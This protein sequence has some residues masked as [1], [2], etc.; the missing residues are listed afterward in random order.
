M[1]PL[2]IYLLKASAT[3]FILWVFYFLCLRR[4]TFHRLNRYFFITGMILSFVWP[5]LPL[6]EWFFT[7]PQ[8]SQVVVYIPVS[9][10]MLELKPQTP[11][12]EIEDFLK[13]CYVGGV[14]FM[15]IRL[16]IQIFFLRKM[17]HRSEKQ[18]I[19]D[20]PVRVIREQINPFSFFGQI[21]LN[22][23][24]H[25]PSEL[26]AIIQHERVHNHRAHSIDILL[27]ELTKIALWFNPFSWLFCKVVKENIEFEVDRILLHQGIDCKSY[28]Y[29]LLKLS[30][31]KNQ[32]P[33][34]NHFNLSNLK[35]RII[36]MNKK[37]SSRFGLATYALVVPILLFSMIVSVAIAQDKLPK[38]KSEKKTAA[39][40]LKDTLAG[41]KPL[42]LLDGV[43]IDKKKMDDIDP[44]K[45]QTVNVLKDDTGA[46][47]EKGK[48][49]VVII[50]SKKEENVEGHQ[51]TFRQNSTGK[52][53]SDVLFVID[54]VPTENKNGDMPVP[55]QIES[56]SIL[57]DK[58]ATALYGERGKNGV[59]LITT[60]AGNKSKGSSVNFSSPKTISIRSANSSSTPTTVSTGSKLDEVVVVGY[61]SNSVNRQNVIKDT[62]KLK[63]TAKDA[64][65][66]LDGAEI[67]EA[68]MKGLEGSEILKVEVL[69]GESATAI[70]GNKGKNGVI[71]ITSKK[72]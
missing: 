57:K 49:G 63:L 22:P 29:S 42:I 69:K 58:S 45:I 48:D 23:A 56:L 7:T 40:V 12:F 44:E 51:I 10:F 53:P 32:I 6:E 15:L 9:A 52:I 20:V 55:E 35:I 8:I 54:G 50:T 64:Y 21:F 2:F 41:K 46:Y 72:K 70:Y 39:I 1:S 34:T 25:S 14:L 33:I 13:I 28:Q 65:I 60:K 37:Q 38:K 62:T 43:E 4:M 17:F 61:G 16:G 71:L 30:T 18:L 59:I 11:A 26:S 66:L 67:D 68:R 19:Q 31:I 5:A 3:V 47:G 27:S 24:H 36:M